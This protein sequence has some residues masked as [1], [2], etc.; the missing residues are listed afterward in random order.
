MFERGQLWNL[1]VSST[2]KAL[3]SGALVSIPTEYEFV[4]DRGVAFVVRIV[5]NLERKEKL[6]EVESGKTSKAF[7]PFLP[8]EKE[9]FVAHV[10]D[11]HLC[12]LNKYNV[13]DHHLLIVTRGFEDQDS[14]LTLSDFEALW[15]CIS[16]YDSLGFYNGGKIAGASQA[17]KH[18]QLVPLPLA[19]R[20]P[21]IPISPLLEQDIPAREIR[22]CERIPFPH[23][24]ARFQDRI[25]ESPSSAA[26]VTLDLYEEMREKLGLSRRTP[27]PFNLLVTREWIL[28]VPRTREFFQSISINSLG[29]VGGFLVR[30][31]EQM[32]R[33][34]NAG[35][36]EAL[37]HT[38]SER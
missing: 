18:L 27:R 30:D 5:T 31:Q 15:I 35:P 3:E 16:E 29:F 28:L 14:S 11:S 12:L 37:I 33:I 8:Y 4:E 34:K 21:G 13:V 26:K 23:R 24:F 1:I 2:D 32:K 7:N 25:W 19:H 22:K 9:L 6:K 38:S 20:G 10:S 17:H 36:M